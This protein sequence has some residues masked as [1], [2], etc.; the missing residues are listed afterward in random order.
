MQRTI[1]ALA[2]FPSIVM[3]PIED[4]FLASGRA[5]GIAD[6]ETAVMLLLC[7]PCALTCSFNALTY[8]KWLHKCVWT[9]FCN[10]RR[11]CLR[12]LH[13]HLIY[14]MTGNHCQTNM[15]TALVCHSLASVLFEL[16]SSLLHTA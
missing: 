16:K 11:A 6:D 14:P 1:S 8:N 2:P 9:S 7:F 10:T 5:A 3:L 4:L 15:A 13:L 12:E